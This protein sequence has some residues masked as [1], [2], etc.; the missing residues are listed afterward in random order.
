MIESRATGE[1]GRDKSKADGDFWLDSNDT[2]QVKWD[3]KGFDASFDGLG[4]YLV[5]A[6]DN[7]A[8]LIIRYKNNESK[9][10]RI[11]TN[12]ANGAVAYVSLKAHSSILGAS[13]VFDNN[14]TDKKGESFTN[15]GWSIDNVSVVKVPEPT[16]I[17]LLSLGLIGLLVARKR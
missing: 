1:F 13:L 15:D 2:Q 7:G 6:N 17:A 9:K 11:D 12:L 3:L 10:I 16:P 4:F 5:D 8:T 14:G